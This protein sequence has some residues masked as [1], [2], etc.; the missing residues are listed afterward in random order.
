[1]NSGQTCV[2]PDYVLVPASLKTAL[3]DRLTQAIREKLPAVSATGK[4]VSQRQVEHL[5]DL[6]QQTQGHIDIGGEADVAQRYLQ[7][8]VVSDVQW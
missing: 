7:A 8:T 1:T 3:V 6:L 2:A 5:L 4:V